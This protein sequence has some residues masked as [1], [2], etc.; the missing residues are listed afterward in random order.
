MGARARDRV[1]ARRRRSIPLQ[2][3]RLR[4]RARGP[5]TRR[6]DRPRRRMDARAAVNRRPVGASYPE[7]SWIGT[8]SS[9]ATSRRVAGATTQPQ[10]T[11]TCAG[12][13]TRSSPTRR[14]RLRRSPRPPPTRSAQIL[15]AAERSVA[16]VRAEASREASDHVSAGPAGHRRACWPSS[17][18]SSPSS[19]ACSPRCAPAANASR[20][21]S[22]EL[23]ADVGGG[24]EPAEPVADEPK[25]APVAPLVRRDDAGARLIALNMALSGS[26]REE[27]A[28]VPR[29]AL[30]ARRPRRAP[31]RRLR[32]GRS[33]NELAEL[34]TGARARD[35]RPQRDR[36]P[37]A[38]GPE[39][40]DA[41]GRGGRARGPVRGARADPARRA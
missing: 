8:E 27:T 41:A 4:T 13:R 33:M 14:C 5:R 15:E 31:R 29:R 19:A 35:R 16:S 22:S 10:W 23:Q 30:R 7:R 17:T 2:G 36:R 21:A 28:R 18:S 6:P 9:A 1:A 25:S 32:Q 37:A 3:E 24:T 38:V 11:S 40:D 26:S 34:P 39:H 12:S 20:P